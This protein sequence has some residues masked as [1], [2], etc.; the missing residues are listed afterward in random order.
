MRPASEIH[1]ALDL[2]QSE[3]EGTPGLL[4]EDEEREHQAG[5]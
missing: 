1:S 2:L 3:L 5:L 4:S